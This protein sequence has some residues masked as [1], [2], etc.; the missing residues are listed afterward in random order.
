MTSV[1]LAVHNK[2][3]QLY[4]KKGGS[5]TFWIKK[6][7]WGSVMV[8]SLIYT[9]LA[10]VIHQVEA[11]VTMSYYQMPEYSGVWSKL[12]MPTAGPPPMSFFISSL[13]LTFVTGVSL[14][15][16]YYYLRDLLPK[17]FWP[18]VLFFADLM[19][20]MSFV[21]FTLPSFLMFNL[22]VQLLVSWFI[23]GFIIL[24]GASYTFVRL[25]K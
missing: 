15:V 18:R 13:I 17:K 16:I 23:S 3:T 7:N 14:A 5:M 6:I 2:D 22:P 1:G 20:G 8:S 9:V 12:M 11:L 19:I 4:K 25:I 21:F 10:T 24:T